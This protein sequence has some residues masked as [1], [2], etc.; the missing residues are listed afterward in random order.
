LTRS[1]VKQSIEVISSD[2]V[3]AY[4]E[5]VLTRE[6]CQHIIALTRNSIQRALVAGESEGFESPARTGSSAGLEHDTDQ[7]I[8]G[9]AERISELVGIPL[10]H[11]E[12]FQVVHYNKGQEY[13]AHYDAHDLGTVMGQN[14]C[15][16]GGQR[17][18]TALVYLNDVSEGGATYF[19]NI[20]I[21]IPAREGRMAI[22]HNTLPGTADIHPKSL[23]AGMPVVDGEKW[24]FNIWFRARPISE[25]QIFADYFSS[26]GADQFQKEKYFVAKGFMN[27][28][29][30]GV[31]YGYAVKK[32]LTGEMTLGD[33]QVP[34]APSSYGDTLMETLLELFRPRVE[35]LTG[36]KLYPSYSYFRLYQHGDE[37]K[38]HVDRPSCEISLVITLGYEA[39]KPWPIFFEL[40][41]KSVPLELLPG[42]AVVYR[43]AEIRHWRESFEGMRH[44]AVFLH[45]VDQNGT[46]AD[47]K[48][49]KRENFHSIVNDAG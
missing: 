43:G 30:L 49:D 36:L 12:T 9:I 27:N 40:D 45:Y 39:A 26:A 34:M 44:A 19:P 20:D 7:I 8:Q 22:F 35:M 18:V 10:A 17:A 32:S 14:F 46:Y 11:A 23:H 1:E 33:D 6:E 41:G 21:S 29:L 47:W 2:P 4:I 31:A 37:L 48:H 15:R 3:V 25:T 42:D 24:A 16:H 13:G 28:A 5:N 38:S